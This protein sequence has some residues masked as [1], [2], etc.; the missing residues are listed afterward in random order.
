M[1]ILKRI[2]NK[3]FWWDLRYDIG[4]FF[5]PRQKWLTKTIP[6]S[7][8]DKPELIRDI[9]FECIIHYVESEKHDFGYGWEEELEKGYITKEKV[10]EMKHFDMDVMSC[11]TYIKNERPQF[12]KQIDDL[13]DQIEVDFDNMFKKSEEHPGY[14]ELV[15]NEHDDKVYKE[16]RKIEAD[17]DKRDQET[18]HIII[19]NRQQ[20]WS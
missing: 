1:K 15:R 19:D 14:Y 2:T 20:L 5:K 3:H 13:Y 11:Y 12:L 7:W 4:N 6:N 18:L 10:R 17:M 8:K 16:I 9:L